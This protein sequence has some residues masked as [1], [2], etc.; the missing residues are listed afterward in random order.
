MLKRCPTLWLKRRHANKDTTDFTA[1]IW[2]NFI[3]IIKWNFENKSL[4]SQVVFF[5]RAVVNSAAVQ[6]RIVVYGSCLNIFNLNLAK[7]EF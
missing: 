4:S 7:I 6:Y 2:Q 5:M 1:E 3:K